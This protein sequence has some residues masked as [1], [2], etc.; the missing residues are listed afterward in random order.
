MVGLLDDVKQR[1]QLVGHNRMELLLFHLDTDQRFGINVFKVREVINCPVL[2]WIPNIHASVR[3]MSNIRGN[4]TSMIDLGMALGRQPM[5]NP[6][7]GLVIVTEFNRSVQGFIVNGVDRIININW[8]EILRPPRG[9]E[10]NSYL[11]AITH[12]GDDMVEIV[13]VE[14]VLEEVMGIQSV[15]SDDIL[16]HEQDLSSGIRHVLVVDDSSVARKQIERTLEQ[17]GVECTIAK[18]GREALGIL[19]HWSDEGSVSDRIAM[20]ISDIEMPEMDGYTLTAEIREDARLQNLY[21]LLHSSLS[22]VFNNAMVKKVG[23]NQFIPKF[24]ADELAEVVLN[25]INGVGVES[26]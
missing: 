9:L 17:V 25:H 11:T 12:V 10:G 8:E 19:N 26:E 6:E 16:K 4:A 15:V 13:D 14:R 22:G 21:V 5:E 3:G 20:I 7:Q 23:A 1:T 18:S 24:S 2:V